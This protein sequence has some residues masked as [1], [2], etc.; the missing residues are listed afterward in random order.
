MTD[1]LKGDAIDGTRPDTTT[2]SGLLLFGLLLFKCFWLE[3][4]Q[5]QQASFGDLVLR[6]PLR[7]SLRRDMTKLRHYSGSAKFIDE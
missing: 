4:L 6:S 3:K 5:K 7:Y 1:L 2:S